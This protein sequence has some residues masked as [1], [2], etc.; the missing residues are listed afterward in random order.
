MAENEESEISES[1]GIMAR[2]LTGSAMQYS[3]AATRRHQA[4]SQARAAEQDRQQRTDAQLASGLR[5]EVYN[6]E[7]W[8]TASS[9]NIAD[10]ITVA[11]H[12]GREH[13]DARMAGMH[14]A[15]VIRNDY[16][17][18]VE[19]IFKDHPTSDMDRHAALRDAL[20]DH[21]AKERAEAD[22]DQGRIAAQQETPT[23]EV[24][25]P[26]VAGA[27]SEAQESSQKVEGAAPV[28]QTAET[29]EAGDRADQARVS[30]SAN[31]AAADKAGAE[32]HQ[33]K[34]NA[35][36]EASVGGQQTDPYQRISRQELNEIQK[37]DPALAAVRQRQAQGF[38]MST[39]AAVTGKG[40]TGP[41]PARGATKGQS[42][43][44]E[45]T[46]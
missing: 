14:A 16:G 29:K 5:A 26:E 46:R 23:A 38:P 28:E 40:E 30:E 11:A 34:E 33:D 39:K 17:I 22:K 27:E 45:V 2:T 4:E 13:P 36:S 1:I 43:D 25:A 44:A 31:L 41:T 20:D 7:F 24:S 42:K 19:D 32:S 3:E 10:H 37:L 15:D 8:R 35:R 6:R 21:F 18:N 9:E 12:L